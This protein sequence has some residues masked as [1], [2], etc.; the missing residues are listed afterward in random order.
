MSTSTPH[1]PPASP[2]AVIVAGGTGNI[3]EG[4]VRAGLSAGATAV[5][6]SRDQSRLD[7]LRRYVVEFGVN[8]AK[9]DTRVADIGDFTQIL[10]LYAQQP[11]ATVHT[12][13]ARPVPGFP[14]QAG[15]G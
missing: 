1:R 14:F 6:P 10:A 13:F 7:A 9:L 4:S 15:G 2:S 5:V 11:K 8:S 12:L 3:G